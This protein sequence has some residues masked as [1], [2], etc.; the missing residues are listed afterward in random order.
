MVMEDRVVTYGMLQDAIGRCA[1]RVAGATIDRHGPV[2]VLVKN[3]IRHLTLSLALFR[4]GIVA[5]SLEHGQS[6]I[7]GR[8]FSAVLGDRDAAS[9]VGPDNRLIEVTD[10]WFA[11]DLAGADAAGAGFTDPT[12]VCRVSLTSGATGVPKVV[13]HSAADF[14][15][16][17]LSLIDVNWDRVLCLPGLS[18]SFGFMTCCAALAT[19]RTVC[20]AESPYQAIRMIELFAIDFVM[21]STEQLLALTRVARKSGARLKSLRTISF[22][23]S[24]PTRILLEAAMIHLCNDI[25]CRYAASETGLVAQATAREMLSAP[26]L[27]GRI[28]P[29]VEVGI[30]GEDG[31]RRA[32]GEAGRVRIRSD[33]AS[34]PRAARDAAAGEHWIDLDDLGSVDAD[35]RLFLLGRASDASGGKLSPVH[36]IEHL[37][38]LEWDVGDAAAVLVDDAGP[39]P[40]IWIGVVDNRSATADQLAALL[41]PLGLQHPLRLFDLQAIPRGSNGKVNRPQLRALM[42]EAAIGTQAR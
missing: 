23:G 2:A 15:A 8:K 32:A 14:G 24:V 16:R 34:V 4:L 28:V 42:R 10:E 3:P 27:V 11:V 6:G 26:G 35:G 21:V 19:G 38:R 30:F 37:L 31:R 1:H 17:I 9:V 18:S 13:E 41:R 39:V 5:V 25:L 7:R 33:A 36:E 20:F 29:G 12:Q 40:Q 22:G